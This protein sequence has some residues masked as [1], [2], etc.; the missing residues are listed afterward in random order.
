MAGGRWHAA[1]SLEAARLYYLLG[2]DRGQS[3]SGVLRF[4]EASGYPGYGKAN[5]ERRETALRPVEKNMKT[6][7]LPETDSVEEL[8]RFWDTHDLTDFDD[9]LEAVTEPVFERKGAWESISGK[10]PTLPATTRLFP[11]GAGSSGKR[12]ILP[13]TL[14]S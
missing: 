2:A 5:D 4:P 12:A 13:T 8:A 9:Q 11:E 14:D 10:K 7:E 6:L 3:L 1:S